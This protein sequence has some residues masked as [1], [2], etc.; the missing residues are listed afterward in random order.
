MWYNE[1][2]WNLHVFYVGTNVYAPNGEVMQ[3]STKDKKIKP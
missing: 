2:C 3:V 1:K